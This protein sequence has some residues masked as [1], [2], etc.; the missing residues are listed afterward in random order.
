MII[1]DDRTTTGLLKTL[2]E[3]EGF[4]VE[5][6]AKGKAALSKAKES[7]PDAFV[8]DL[9]LADSLGTDLIRQLRADTQFAKSAIVMTSGLP[10]GDDALASGADKFMLKPFDPNELIRLLRELIGVS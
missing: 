6:V 7:Q 5:L 3:L 8:V 9:N 10:K 1:D 4:E 2:F